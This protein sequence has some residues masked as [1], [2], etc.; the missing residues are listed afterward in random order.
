M[1]LHAESSPE[2]A[3][4]LARQRRN[5][6]I[7]ALLISILVI[8]LIALILALILLPS[9]MKET[10]VIVSYSA[11]VSDDEQLTEKKV[12]TSVDR[13]PSAPS[14]A[15]ARV[16]ASATASP[17]SIPVVDVPVD[18]VSLEFGSGDDFGAGWDSG[19]SMGSGGGGATFFNQKVS[20]NRIAYV[21]DYSASMRSNG[22]EDLMRSE[23]AKS[24]KGLSVGTF[25]QLFFFAGPVWVAGDSVSIRMDG[26]DKKAKGTSNVT[27]PDGEVYKWTGVGLNDWTPV[28]KPRKVP[29]I[30]MMPTKQ[31]ESLKQIKEGKLYLGTD[32]ENPIE[33]AMAMDP[34]PQVIFFMTDGVMGGRD[35]EKLTR[36][37][38][39]QAKKKG[40]IINTIALMEPRAEESM[41]DLAKRAGGVFT[42][43]EKN[44][45]S[46]EV[47]RAGKG[48]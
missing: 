1:S 41:L 27:D 47:K 38:G 6:G 10:P 30:Q 18:N 34:P 20:G 25:Y 45:K 15:S 44:G 13:K 21:I 40:I 4:R 28:G 29:W 2:A 7:S 26:Q 24:I 19:D 48:K 5:S 23:L 3:E 35:M 8:G 39:G 43:V 22:R 32:W 12:K 17:V 33:M 46:R 11:T 14:S 37:L 42:I 9:W 16:I 31:R 36:D